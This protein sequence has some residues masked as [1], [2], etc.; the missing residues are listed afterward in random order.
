MCNVC[1]KMDLAWE[2]R[3]IKS[4]MFNISQKVYY[5]KRKGSTEVFIFPFN[6]M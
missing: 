5:M 3:V 6:E 4:S 1:P 2:N